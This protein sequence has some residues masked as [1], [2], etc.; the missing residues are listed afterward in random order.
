M[1]YAREGG[2]KALTQTD[3]RA[4][5]KTKSLPSM[6]PPIV[7]KGRP[8]MALIHTCRSAAHFGRARFVPGGLACA[9]AARKLLLSPTPLHVS[10]TLKF[11]PGFWHKSVPR[12][13]PNAA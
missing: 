3:S 9:A 1:V 5:M 11:A 12:L 13:T 8:F 6:T 2:S 10:S 7:K 4:R